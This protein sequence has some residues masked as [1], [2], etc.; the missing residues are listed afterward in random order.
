MPNMIHYVNYYPLSIDSNSTNQ[1]RLALFNI[2]LC[3]LTEFIVNRIFNFPFQ[4]P[5]K[6]DPKASKTSQK[7]KDG[8][9]S[10]GKA[11]KKVRKP[12]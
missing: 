4:P 1:I 9:S 7:K 10:G 6:P 8:A 3:V 12:L 5:K 11:K 2:D